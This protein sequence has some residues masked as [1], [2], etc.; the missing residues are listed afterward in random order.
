MLAQAA[1]IVGGAAGHHVDALQLFQIF[2][3]EL[4][5]VQDDTAVADSRRNGAP[6]SLGLLVDLLDHEVIVAALFGGGNVPVDGLGNLFHGI[7]EGVV[8][9]GAVLGEDD[10]VAVVQIDHLAG[11]FQN[12]GHVGGD[13]ILSLAEAED[14]R[15]FLLHRDHGAGQILAENAQGVAALQLTHSPAHGPGEVLELVVIVFHQV[16]YH[17]GVGL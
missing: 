1:H 4:D 11:V 5:I 7:I 8:E 15:A 6:D 10:G 17:L 2:L 16:G 12:R 14:Q 13:E 9:A 3:G